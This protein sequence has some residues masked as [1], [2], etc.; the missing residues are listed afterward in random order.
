[1]MTEAEVRAFIAGRR[2]FNFDPETRDFAAEV[3][4]GPDGRC[5]LRFASGVEEGG[6]WG[7]EADAYWTRYDAFRG[8]ERHAFR[9]EPL[10]PGLAQAWF[11]T[12]A[13][14]F[15]QSHSRDLPATGGAPA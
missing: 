3:V 5:A 14:A 11:T 8:G 9:L 10:A 6:V 15:L 7:F 2:V 13:R 1:M 12:G 4:Y